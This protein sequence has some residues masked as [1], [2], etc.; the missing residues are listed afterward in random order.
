VKITGKTRVVG[1][2]GDPVSHSISPYMHNAAFEALGLDFVYA[3]FR[4][5][6]EH[7]KNSVSAIRALDLA[8]INIT[9][10]HKERV[11]EFLDGTSKEAAAIGAVNTIVNKG[12]ILTGHN[13]DGRGWLMSLAGETGFDPGGKS[14]ILLGAGGSARAIAFTILDK[15]AKALVVANRTVK[16]AELLARELSGKFPRARIIASTLDI[17]R[18]IGEADLIVNTTS[19]GMLA[20]AGEK[21]PVTIEG[22]RPD[23][24]V[25]DIVYRPLDTPLIKAASGLGLKVHKGFGMLV[26]QGALA[27]E[28]WTG[29]PAPIDTMR[30][31]GLQALEVQA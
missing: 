19:S 25:S 7:L 9:V 20:S 10:P 22:I 1:I 3:A 24:I 27:F 29:K 14:V 21:P 13:T 2:F 23:A 8:G 16:K 18:Y 30:F 26:H 5:R 12:G 11:M 31:A 28:L 17:A 6:P 15:A 4:V